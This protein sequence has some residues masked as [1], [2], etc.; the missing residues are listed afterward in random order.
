MPQPHT[1]MGLFLK[2]GEINQESLLE[3]SDGPIVRIVHLLGN[4]RR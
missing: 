3:R 2:F 4:A 1:C